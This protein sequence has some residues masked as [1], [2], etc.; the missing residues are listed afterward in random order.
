MRELKKNTHGSLAAMGA[1]I[2]IIVTLMISL[3][4]VY[5]IVS[6]INPRTIDIKAQGNGMPGTRSDAGNATNSTISGLNTFYTLA[7]LI[8]VVIA[9][10]IILAYVTRFGQG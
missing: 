6:S 7:P 1:A 8:I 5:S 9:A 10:V 2:A 4:I 3:V